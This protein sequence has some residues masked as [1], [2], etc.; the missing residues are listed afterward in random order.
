[1]SL[2]RQNVFVLLLIWFVLTAACQA[3]YAL[4]SGDLLFYVPFDGS[5]RAEVAGGSKE[6]T[7]GAAEFVE[8]IRGQGALIGGET[9]P[10]KYHIPGNFN[11][12]QGTMSLW[13]KP[14]DWKREDG[15][16]HTFLVFPG[17]G[18]VV[19]CYLLYN[20]AVGYTWFLI[21][22]PGGAN[23]FIGNFEPKWEPGKWHHLVATW[24][25]GEVCT[26]LDGEL[27]ARE[28]EDIPVMEN[29]APEFQVGDPQNKTVFDELMIFNRPLMPSEVKA[30][31]QKDA[32]AVNKT[33][34]KITIGRAKIAPTIDAVISPGEWD[35]SASI[36]NL[37]DTF[38]G[39]SIQEQYSNIR[40]SYDDKNVYLAMRFPIPE[41][42]RR[43]PDLYPRG[44]LKTEIRENDGDVWT[45][46]SFEV[47][48]S[49]D[50]S[51]SRHTY[52]WV[53]NSI[54]TCFDSRD[55]QKEWNS[56]AVIKSVA[57]KNNWILEAAIPFTD[58]GVSTPADGD[59]WQVNLVQNWKT[60][61]SQTGA[62][63][64]SGAMSNLAFSPKTPIVQVNSIGQP[65]QGRM[66]L[67]GSVSNPTNT[68]TSVVITAQS[69]GKEINESTT[70]NL[71]PG[72]CKNFKL[73]STVAEQ[74]A[75]TLVVECKDSS[76][77]SLYS[78]QFPFVFRPI[79]MPSLHLLPS[80][81]LL[82]VD[83]DRTGAGTRPGD[84]S[85]FAD[86]ALRPLGSK[87]ALKHL[88]SEAFTQSK[89]TMN[90]D[91]ADLAPGS[92][93]VAASLGTSDR[94]LGE[95]ILKFEKKI[96]P[97]WLNNK[98]GFSEKVP[99]P[100]I[101]LK[102]QKT[103]SRLVKIS[104]WGRTYEF[105]GSLFPSQI[106]SQRKPLLSYPIRLVINCSGNIAILQS[107]DVTVEKC[108][109]TQVVL[110]SK[111]TLDYAHIAVKTTIEYDGFI[112]F[113][114]SI[115]NRAT[116]PIESLAFE[117][118]YALE[119]A[120]LVYNGPNTGGAL[121]VGE[122]K[123]QYTN[124]FWAGCEN[125]GIEWVSES[126]Q[127]WKITKP[128]QTIEVLNGSKPGTEAIAR[129]NIIDAPTTIAK[130]LKISFGIEATP[131]RPKP[132]G[133]R[134]WRLTSYEHPKQEQ[135]NI[136]AKPWILM[137]NPRWSQYLNY[138]VVNPEWKPLLKRRESEGTRSCLYAQIMRTSPI[139]PEYRYFYEEWRMTPST[140]V[141]FDTILENIKKD[142]NPDWTQIGSAPVC[143]KSS[144]TDFYMWHL[145]QS[146]KEADIKGYYFD[147]TGPEP[148][149]NQEHGCGWID[150]NGEVQAIWPIRAVREFLK[151]TYVIIKENDPTSIIGMHM[152]GRNLAPMDAFCD[153]MIDGELFNQD[154]QRQ[155]AA[156]GKDNGY[157]D[158][159]T[160][161]KMRAEYMSS[162]WGP[163]T[164]FLPA[165]VPGAGEKYH[166][167]SPE[168]IANIEHLVGLFTLH[169]S[170][171]WP[172]W[173]NPKPLYDTWAAQQKF[174]WDD[175]VKFVPYWDKRIND[176]VTV[177]SSGVQPVVCSIFRRADKVMLVL[178]NNSDTDTEVKI[179]LHPDK[180]GM[181]TQE[182]PGIRDYYSSGYFYNIKDEKAAWKLPLRKRNFR[183]LVPGK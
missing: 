123:S 108:S 159:L 84:K 6:Q 146:V 62:I 183:M 151:R 118:P 8:G 154:I 87:K 48:F 51:G 20:Y 174:G 60:L 63:A 75:S 80:K 94:K 115:I 53:I 82:V 138:P 91:I 57:D 54:G 69:T 98:A 88:H 37:L 4:D 28:T 142:K 45:D 102:V 110:V 172:A 92:Y 113:D 169:D 165:F 32:P 170:Q 55:G 109:E 40:M 35:D 42:V 122:Y 180:L 59:I 147:L 119:Y 131:V 160:L 67:E 83:I 81:N 61:S 34:E 90:V 155:I 128:Q 9:A 52:R 86:V 12:D 179:H 68:A 111:C 72:A 3:V 23:R 106:T 17:E 163:L 65:D 50:G 150:D 158:F 166:Q 104:C 171:M 41:E 175:K 168:V 178:F 70:L 101:P 129:F 156:K 16:G 141:D 31:Y 36:G 100:F 152:S 2:N 139:P 76:G 134:K 39:K 26:Y 117:V 49:P 114:I 64:L 11:K 99:P 157:C 112:W 97:V 132:N 46:D 133:W 38:F 73:Q 18:P 96:Q 25:K 162:T 143:V 181:T 7:S 148:C 14:V 130:P 24:K 5:T 47:I 27:Q 125:G 85:F 13:I 127:G 95:K 43:S 153:V 77:R 137:W 30:L 173:M 19:Q 149:S 107:G 164:A 182:F 136:D 44:P 58:M 121:K 105:N 145:K 116:L 10:L 78:R 144:F 1:M 89:E 33:Q 79:F 126:Q 66:L 29:A 22:R 140:Q 124:Y 135:P 161:D 176:Y 93:V 71:E 56:K 103:G 120:T 177:D 15:K 21:M 74:T 167:D